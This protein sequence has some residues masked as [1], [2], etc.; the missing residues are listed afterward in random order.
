MKVTSKLHVQTDENF[1]CKMR[2]Y[3]TKK[4][5]AGS[6]RSDDSSNHIACAHSNSDLEVVLVD[7]VEGFDGLQHCKA[8]VGHVHRRCLNRVHKGQAGGNHILFIGR[9]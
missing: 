9:E 3:V 4:A 8:K 2:T 5:V 6:A 7:L 1:T